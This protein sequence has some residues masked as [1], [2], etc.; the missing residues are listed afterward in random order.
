MT[1][2]RSDDASG[3]REE[4]RLVTC[5]FIDIVGSTDL[6]ARLGPERLKRALDT[7]FEE[8]RGR[9]VAEGGTVEK[10]IGDAVYALFGAPSSH[11]DDPLRALR[12]AHAC[13]E[14]AARPD[15]PFAVRIGVETGE[16]VVDLTAAERTHQR[17]SVGPVVNT[18]ARLE[19]A[20][21]PGQ[22]LVGPRCHE[23]TAA[24]ARFRSL[25]SMTF[26]GLAPMD[27]W[28]LDAPGEVAVAI[29]PPFVGRGGELE[30]LRLAHRRSAERAVLAMVSGPPGQGKTRV[31]RQLF[32]G[33]GREP[34]IARFRPRGEIAATTPLHALLGIESADPA[35]VWRALRELPADERDRIAHGVLH[36]SGLVPDERLGRLHAEERLDE[37]VHAWR[38]YLT[39]RSGGATPLVWFEDVHWADDEAVRLLDRLTLSTESL[40]LVA[41]ARPEFAQAAGLRPGGDRFFVEIG[42]LDPADAEALARSAGA[43]QGGMVQRAQGNP[44][45]IVELARAGAGGAE[46]PLTLQGALGARLDELAPADRE[47]LSRASIAGET[48]DVDDAV[49]LSGLGASEVATALGRLADLLYLR[50]VGAAYRFHHGLLRD[51]AYG[52]LLVADRMRLHARL[53]AATGRSLDPDVR[54]HHWWEAVRPPDAEWAWADGAELAALRRS[55][56]A[57]HLAAA[58]VHLARHNGLRAEAL[59]AR[60]AELAV[61]PSDAARVARSRGRAAAI[62][63]RGDDAWAHY[64]RTADLY[65]EMGAIPADLYPDWLRPAII[66]Y[67]SFHQRPPVERVRELLAEGERRAV[68]TGDAG[69]QRLLEILRAFD[70]DDA[71][72]A[73]SAVERATGVLPAAELAGALSDVASLQFHVGDIAAMG[74]TVEQLGAMS[75]ATADPEVL[76]VTRRRIAIWRGDIAEARRLALALEESTRPAG[77]H[78]R[79]HAL[80]TL[81]WQ[82]SAE[83]DWD[84]LRRIGAE[85]LTLVNS[86]DGTKF[87]AMAHGGL[88]TVAL[89]E[90]REGRVDEARALMARARALNDEID[91][92][93][94]SAL[95]LLGDRSP[96]G[97]PPAAESPHLWTEFGIAC[98][99]AGERAQAE[100]AIARL[101]TIAA[102]GAWL[103]G[104]TAAAMRDEL[105]GASLSGPGHAALRSRGYA[106]HSE[107]LTLRATR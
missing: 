49:V 82:S 5:L 16:A 80:T 78:I 85:L 99:I 66:G 31:V 97:R 3:G 51:V 46:M 104:A 70:R 20:A 7:A 2:E 14:W 54:A 4:R 72:L 105:S 56:T 26:K 60:A 41:T 102:R 34:L 107:I 6:T 28:E 9:I 61:D 43:A 8:V 1:T 58:D 74:R 50:R 95:V 38:R 57:A 75:G 73:T 68:D 64:S 17:M 62:D 69:S 25:G 35:E 86:N 89:G 48:F 30:I 15:A 33:I 13:R 90:L 81:A 32:D 22:V 87:C 93:D 100:D 83:G 52:R 55:A 71:A 91:A 98:V 40:L 101:E 18:A 12:A 44:L 59:L 79:S 94:P 42:P 76:F 84:W 10:Y 45:F 63:R 47:L 103:A 37:I 88:S 27:V 21:D 39:I 11:A 65:R 19:Q 92:P 106:G 96:L 53:A 23:A 36:S 77:P 29:D 24:Y 67:G